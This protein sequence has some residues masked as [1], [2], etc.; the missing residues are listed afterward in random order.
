MPFLVGL[1]LTG[2]GLAAVLA[3]WLV[4]RFSRLVPRQSIPGSN[5]AGAMERRI[6]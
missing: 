4:P 6:C 2:T 1:A 3:L 5:I